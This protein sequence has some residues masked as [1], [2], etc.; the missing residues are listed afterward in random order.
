[1]HDQ[2]GVHLADTTRVCFVVNEHTTKCSCFYHACL[3]EMHQVYSFMWLNIYLF[4]FQSWELILQL[5]LCRMM[6]LDKTICFYRCPVEVVTMFATS[7]PYGCAIMMS[8]IAINKIVSQWPLL[9]VAMLLR[10]SLHATALC[11]HA[12]WMWRHT[13]HEWVINIHYQ[14]LITQ[15][16]FI[17]IIRTPS[18]QWVCV[19]IDT[20]CSSRVW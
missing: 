6:K 9:Y 7:G 1:M 18:K 19:M 15:G 8:H 2:A 3:F 4:S 5:V 20:H 14:I 16:R 13:M 10:V 11:R 17:N 12:V